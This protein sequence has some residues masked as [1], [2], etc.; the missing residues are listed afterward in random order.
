MPLAEAQREIVRT[1]P[2]AGILVKNEQPGQVHAAVPL[3]GETNVAAV[4]ILCFICLL[5]GIIYAVVSSRTRMQPA[6]VHLAP[7]SPGTTVITIQAVPAA[8]QVVLAALGTLPW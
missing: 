5:P 8:R 7:S 4:I 6:V 1:L 3:K 2:M